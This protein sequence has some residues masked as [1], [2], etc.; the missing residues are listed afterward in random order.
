MEN[1]FDLSKLNKVKH[2]VKAT[3]SLVPELTLV[4]TM[5]KFSL[6]AVASKLLKLVSGQ[7]IS[8]IEDDSVDSLDKRFYL[9]AGYGDDAAK[10]AASNKKEEDG[11]SLQFTWAGI[12]GRMMAN[13]PN[14]PEL[15]M[16]ALV[17]MG[18]M[19]KRQ[20]T[21]KAGST[22]EP[23]TAYSAAKK[24]V[25]GIE[26]AGNVQLEGM[27]EAQPIYVLVRPRFVEYTARVPKA[28]GQ[29]GEGSIDEPLEGTEIEE[30][31]D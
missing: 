26:L 20:T 7:T 13:K 5:N 12:Y 30:D 6:N 10:L 23:N 1:G 2:N 25:F 29:V 28:A 21:P 14:S 4:P 11:L 27:E 9:T 15:P 22:G 8:F 17:E 19:V 18:V 31:N 16:E 3:G 24:L